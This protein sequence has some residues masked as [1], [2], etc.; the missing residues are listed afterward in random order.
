MLVKLGVAIELARL[1][2]P[3]VVSLSPFRCYAGL[4]LLLCQF[5]RFLLELALDLRLMLFPHMMAKASIASLLEQ[6]TMYMG[7]WAVV[8]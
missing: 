2:T 3:T 1:E 8:S 7:V 4:L 6:N 5:L